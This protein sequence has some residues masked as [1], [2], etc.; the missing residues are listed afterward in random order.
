MTD[1]SWADMMAASF[2]DTGFRPDHQ[3]RKLA[4][5]RAIVRNRNSTPTEVAEA[6]QTLAESPYPDDRIIGLALCGGL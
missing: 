2:G 5:A 3:E 4:R 1:K 6:A